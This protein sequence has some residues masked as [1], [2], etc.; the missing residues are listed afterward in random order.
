MLAQSGIC[1]KRLT[2]ISLPLLSVKGSR[3]LTEPTG[4]QDPQ[5]SQGPQGV[6][7]VAGPVTT[8]SPSGLTRH[9]VFDVEGYGPTGSDIQTTITFPLSSALTVVVVPAYLT[10]SDPVHCAGSVSAPTTARGYLGIYT[11][12]AANNSGAGGYLL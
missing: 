1:G 7:G 9:G 12:T 4:S 8:T 5:G 6:H 3:G 2:K 11:E 10:N